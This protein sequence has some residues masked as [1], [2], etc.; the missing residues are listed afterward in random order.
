MRN[1]LACNNE[2]TYPHKESCKLV[3]QHTVIIDAGCA[4]VDALKHYFLYQCNAVFVHAWKSIRAILA[5]RNI[6]FLITLTHPQLLQKWKY[7]HSWFDNPIENCSIDFD[8]YPLNIS[9]LFDVNAH[10]KNKRMPDTLEGD[11][12]RLQTPDQSA[13]TYNIRSNCQC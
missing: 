1:I 9:F 5:R 4:S 11:L 10:H 6:T 8:G 13:K 7:Y 3:W 2:P 12:Y